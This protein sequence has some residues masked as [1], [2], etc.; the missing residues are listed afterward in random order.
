MVPIY[1]ATDPEDEDQSPDNIIVDQPVEPYKQQTVEEDQTLQEETTSNAQFVDTPPI[2][3]VIV[4]L[5]PSAAENVSNIDTR[6]Q[7]TRRP[8]EKLQVQW[9]SKSY[10]DSH[11]SNKNN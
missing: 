11:S 9:N 4:P 7:R 3:D 10:T 1:P 5:H 8:V 6:P 2:P